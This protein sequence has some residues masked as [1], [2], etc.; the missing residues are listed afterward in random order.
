MV[1][2]TVLTAGR[3]SYGKCEFRPSYSS[4]PNEPIKMA[5][6]TRD[7]VVETTPPANFHQS[8][9]FGLPPEKG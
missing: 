9:H 2:S 4:A 8:A 7:Y 3:L 5:F 6:G 1:P